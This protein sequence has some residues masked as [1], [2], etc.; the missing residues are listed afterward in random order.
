MKNAIA[1]TRPENIPNVEQNKPFAAFGNLLQ[2]KK[3]K[4]KIASFYCPFESQFFRQHTHN[5]L[6]IKK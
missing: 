2:I 5:L 1:N 4:T 3:K 6:C